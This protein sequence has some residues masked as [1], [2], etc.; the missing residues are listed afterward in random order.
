[1]NRSLFKDLL[2]KFSKYS[3]AGNDFLLFEC[4][5]DKEIQ[6]AAQL[7]HAQWEK[8]CQ[9]GL[10]VGA[11][12]VLF[13]SRNPY[14]MDYINSDGHP[15]EMCGNGLRAICS[16]IAKNDQVND[17]PI[18]VIT[19]NFTYKA[20]FKDNLVW[21]EMADISQAG[22]IDCG[23]MYSE[24]IESYFINTGVPHVVF[25]V[26]DIEKIDI[27]SVAAPIR[28][29]K[30]FKNGSNV[31]FFEVVSPG[32]L[33]MRVFERGVEG[34]TLSSGTG[35]TAVGLAYRHLHQFDG[36]LEINPPGGKMQMRFQEGK[37]WL[38]GPV[39]EVFQ[40][41]LNESFLV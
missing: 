41:I 11:D 22:E 12:G 37:A 31:N 24:A 10:G 40:A 30:R 14:K 4:G 26:K 28:A 3:S 19:Q 20:D 38:T 7:S 25:Q 16:H 32:N 35:T 33:K 6:G 18:E 29:D 36:D 5:E 27:N 13:L 17:W 21:I 34:E 39:E 1:M 8:V 15:A 9:R 23:D 2:L